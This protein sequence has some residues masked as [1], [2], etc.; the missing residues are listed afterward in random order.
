MVVAVV[1]GYVQVGRMLVV[2]RLR[3]IGLGT[4]GERPG[5]GLDPG[6]GDGALWLVGV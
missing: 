2:W 3:L 5:L 1:L 4:V 6:D